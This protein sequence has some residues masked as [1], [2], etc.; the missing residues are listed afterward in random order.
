MIH[1]TFQFNTVSFG[2]LISLIVDVL[3]VQDGVRDDGVL[4]ALCSLS[5]A[6]ALHLFVPV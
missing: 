1:L 3:G 5:Y 4:N 6:L 2:L